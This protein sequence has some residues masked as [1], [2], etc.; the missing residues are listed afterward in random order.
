MLLVWKRSTQKRSLSCKISHVQEV[1]K[2]G[3]YAAV[4]RSS[5]PSVQRVDEET[6]A[7]E[8]ASLF[9]IGQEK[10]SNKNKKGAFLGVITYN[11][12]SD[13][14]KASVE[15]EGTEHIFK[16]DTRADVTVV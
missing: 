16:L 8:E 11:V 13:P 3:H 1:L 2:D 6:E 15:L 14:W 10:N 7:G 5:Y 4:C 9:M 12:T